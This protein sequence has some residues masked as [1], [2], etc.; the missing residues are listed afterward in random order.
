MEGGSDAPSLNSFRMKIHGTAVKSDFSDLGVS[1]DEEGVLAVAEEVA[2]GVLPQTVR[3]EH[4]VTHLK[5]T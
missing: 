3:L 2:L 4:Y 5:L 1:Q